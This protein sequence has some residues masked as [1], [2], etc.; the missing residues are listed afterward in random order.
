MEVKDQSICCLTNTFS[1]KPQQRSRTCIYIFSQ[2][3][4]H[5]TP[6]VDWPF[7]CLH[8]MT[9]NAKCN[10]TSRARVNGLYTNQTSVC[11]RVCVCNLRELVTVWSIALN[12]W[13]CP[14][15]G[16]PRRLLP[17][18]LNEKLAFHQNCVIFGKATA[19]GQGIY[20]WARHIPLLFP[21]MLILA[22][23]Q[24]GW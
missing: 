12:F 10:Y 13:R 7:S 11:V 2:P 14:R 15:G 22:H 18:Q 19:H 16:S 20:P 8:P 3:L 1:C 9:F 5:H 6:S 23:E 17:V 24:G 4:P 21:T